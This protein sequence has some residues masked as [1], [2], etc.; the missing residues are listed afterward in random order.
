MGPDARR[1]WHAGAGHRVA[2]PFNL[3]W[4]LPSLCGQRLGLWWT[5][6]ALGWVHLACGVALLSKLDRWHTIAAAAL[7]VALPGVLGPAVVRP[8]GVDLPAMGWAAFGAGMITHGHVAIGVAMIVVSA[9]MKETMP[10]WAALW[11]WSLWP[12]VALLAPAV[13]FLVVRSE[14]DPITALPALKAVHDHPIRT[15]IEAHKGRWR[16]AWLMVAP[17]GVCLLALHDPS[18]PL[19]ACLVLAYAQLLVATDSVRLFQ[20]AAGPSVALAAAAVIPTAWLLP[21][22]VAHAFW[23]RRPEMI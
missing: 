17:W 20:T 16:D 10:V 12:L 7:V 4:L 13:A 23:W 21:A 11:C 8:V 15:A 5:A 1:Y 6:W 3:R 9:A 2:R 22:V 18:W 19:A 14:L